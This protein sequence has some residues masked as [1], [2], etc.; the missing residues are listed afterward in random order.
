[1]LRCLDNCLALI[2]REDGKLMHWHMV[3]EP[4]RRRDALYCTSPA[5]D[6][7]IPRLADPRAA[8]NP[9]HWLPDSRH[10]AGDHELITSL[11]D[12]RRWRHIR[13]PDP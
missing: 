8:E 7:P 11:N 12:L 2:G 10:D 5:P 4:G 3:H 6:C 13:L 1:M 9:P